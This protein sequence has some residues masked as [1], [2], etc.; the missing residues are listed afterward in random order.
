[1][2][3]TWLA[4]L[5][6]LAFSGIA[7]NAQDS[8]AATNATVISESLSMYSEMSVSSKVVGSLKKGDRVT[9]GLEIRGSDGAWCG[10]RGIAGLT[11]AA[12]VPCRGLERDPRTAAPAPTALAPLRLEWPAWLMAPDARMISQR[13]KA[14][15]QTV[16]GS[17]ETC[18][19]DVLGK[20]SQGCLERVYKSTRALS[21]LYDYFGDLLGQNGYTTHSPSNEPYADLPLGNS[22][23]EPFAQLNMRE[24][25]VPMDATQYRQIRIFMRQP[26]TPTTQVEITFMVKGGSEEASPKAPSIPAKLGDDSPAWYEVMPRNKNDWKWAIQSVAGHTA[27]GIKYTNYYYEQATG[28]SVDA[29]LPLPNGGVIVH[30]F[31][32][33]AFYLE[34]EKGNR[35]KFANAKE[36][37]GKAVGP[38]NWTV[39]PIKVGGVDVFFNSNF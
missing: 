39:Y 14:A 15:G 27:A 31:P 1:M 25:P 17:A 4:L 38:G 24:Y 33:C 5:C 23:G 2:I 36:A 29:R 35:M 20:P 10:V 21:D 11:G 22:I 26:Q 7:G 19:G 37:R 16:R 32:D 8:Q 9:V 13:T 28:R 6:A 30:V 3:R 34:D 18:P 12:Y